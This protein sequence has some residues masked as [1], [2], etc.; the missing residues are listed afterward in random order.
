MTI[1]RTIIVALLGVLALPLNAHAATYNATYTTPDVHWTYSEADGP[2]AKR[3]PF[4]IDAGAGHYQSWSHGSWRFNAPPTTKVI[5]GTINGSYAT[6][7][8]AMSMRIRAGSGATSTT[9]STREGSGIY[10]TRPTGSYNWIETALWTTSA[11]DPAT[12]AS[13]FV[14]ISTA[15]F[16]LSDD[17]APSLSTERPHDGWHGTGCLPFSY[18]AA[19]AGSGVW[20]AA[21]TNDLLGGPIDTY[22]AQHATPARP[23]ATNLQRIPCI[24]AVHAGTNTIT[25]H[26]RDYAGNTTQTSFG[27]KFDLV[28][29]TVD[30]NLAN[31]ATIGQYRPSL[32]FAID[33]TQSGVDQVTATLDGQAIATT[34]TDGVLEYAPTSDLELGQH[35]VSVTATDNVGNKTTLIRTFTVRDLTQP[36][37]VINAP[38][39][40]GS[41]TPVLDASATDD[42][43]GIDESTWTVTVNKRQLAIYPHNGRVLVDIGYLVNQRH[44]IVVSVRDNS[45]NL[46]TSHISYIARSSSSAGMLPAKTGLFAIDRQRTTRAGR[47]IRIRAAAAID[48]RPLAG[49]RAELRQGGRTIAGKL[50]APDG[51][52][53]IQTRIYNRRSVYI[54][55]D[56]SGLAKQRV[57]LRIR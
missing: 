38:G 18:T 31:A 30:T 42:R 44:D 35:Q 45:G 17:T 39:T 14:T 21:A 52:V 54:V 20:T 46:R 15:T 37:L 5:D 48:G 40:S 12:S 28:G 41:N 36:A 11:S 29:P 2:Y 51:T 56:G 4:G 34:L 47:T 33:D 8:S 43:T 25:L 50:I 1:S 6:P 3:S 24:P 7:N 10:T 19:D 22:Q 57:K 49:M 9:I 16:T 55:V 13:N 26:A 27:V 53:D 32:R 23:G